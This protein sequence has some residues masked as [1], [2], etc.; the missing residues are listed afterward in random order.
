MSCAKW[1]LRSC[2]LRYR[3]PGVFGNCPHPQ[4]QV[5]FMMVITAQ[6]MPSLLHPLYAHSGRISPSDGT[7]GASCTGRRDKASHF[8]NRMH[9]TPL[10]PLPVSH[11]TNAYELMEDVNRTILEDPKRLNMESWVSVFK[12]RDV[13]RGGI[14][15]IKVYEEP[16]CGT[17][18]CYAGWV[19]TLTGANPLYGLAA[20]RVA[21][22]T[23][24]GA[25]NGVLRRDLYAAFINTEVPVLEDEDG[26]TLRPG[27]PSYAAAVI[28]RF[29][30]IMDK[31]EA[32]L[33]ATSVRID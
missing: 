30:A 21:L 12:G 31:H 7:F 3:F 14:Y 16:A 28:A 13:T 22:R 17:V 4:S 27:T 15:A 9:M 6:V 2:P 20:D 33:R 18:C 25:A 29:Q 24:G 5:W 8:K 19:A 32:H 26:W 1:C 11:A 10:A 23:L